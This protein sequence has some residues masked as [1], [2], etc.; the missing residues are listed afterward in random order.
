M[1]FG[2]IT[3]PENRRLHD[4]TSRELIALAPLVAM[5][6]VIGWFPNI[7]L[8]QIHDAAARMESDMEERIANHPPPKFYNGM[9]RLLPRSPDAPKALASVAAPASAPEAP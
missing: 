2:P 9:L 3:K 8:S 1:F 4:V 6:F 7:F 5:I